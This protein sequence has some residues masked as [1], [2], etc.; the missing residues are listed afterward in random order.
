VVPYGL[1][2]PPVTTTRMSRPECE[3]RKSE[4]I[5]SAG[6]ISRNRQNIDEMNFARSLF[7]L[8][9]LLIVASAIPVDK[10]DP[11]VCRRIQ[12]PDDDLF[13]IEDCD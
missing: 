8:A 9:S 2:K 1:G 13:P 3:T 12:E 11:A 10:R 5:S 4:G 7:Y 6:L